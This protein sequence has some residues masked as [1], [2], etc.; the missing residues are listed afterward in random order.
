MQKSACMYARKALI[1]KTM[2]VFNVPY[3]PPMSKSLSH[4]ERRGTDRSVPHLF[5]IRHASQPMR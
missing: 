3:V 1:S 5:H 4:S 2:E